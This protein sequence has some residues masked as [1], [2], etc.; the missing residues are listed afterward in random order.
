[1][2][3]GSLDLSN[4]VLNRDL[5][6]ADSHIVGDIF[7]WGLQGHQVSLQHSS[8]GG[9]LDMSYSKVTLD[10][11]LEHFSARNVYFHYTEVGRRLSLNQATIMGEEGPP[12][13]R[14]N[15]QSGKKTKTG[16][17]DLSGAQI[18]EQLQMRGATVRKLDLSNATITALTNFSEATVLG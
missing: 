4:I 9:D 13:V 3:T 14:S 17:L 1:Q 8:A 6:I 10:V 2:I 11:N 18:G 5:I 7:L 12:N 16:V 15:V